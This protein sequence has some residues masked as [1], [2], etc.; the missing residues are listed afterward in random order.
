MTTLVHEP[1]K[2]HSI[3]KEP[4]R[5]A[6]PWRQVGRAA[7]LTIA[8]SELAATLSPDPVQFLEQHRQLNGE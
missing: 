8:H 5:R 7:I 1:E 3:T 6:H 4:L 2:Q